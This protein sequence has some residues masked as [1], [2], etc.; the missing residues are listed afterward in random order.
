[1]TLEQLALFSGLI[2]A[3]IGAAASS[4]AIWIQQAHQNKRE[5]ARLSLDAAVKE[6]TFDQ[7]YAK[8][9]AEQGQKTITRDL[10]HKTY[11][12]LRLFHQMQRRKIC[13]EDVLKIHKEAL[14]ISEA[15][16]QFYREREKDAQQHAE[17]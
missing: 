16:N 6:L 8:F 1:M 4:V 7:E 15:V 11:I 9:M 13:K 10:F 3:I 14:E 17:E 12:Q 2:G 5:Q